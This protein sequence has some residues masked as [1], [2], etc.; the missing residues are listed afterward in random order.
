MKVFISWSGEQS[1]A[2]AKAL[3]EGLPLVPAYNNC[4]HPSGLGLKRK[5]LKSLKKRLHTN[6]TDHKMKFWRN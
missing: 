4:F 6:K 2:L 3:H 1:Q 5:F